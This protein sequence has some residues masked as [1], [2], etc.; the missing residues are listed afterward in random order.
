MRTGFR[1]VWIMCW[2]IPI[3][4]WDMESVKKIAESVGEVVV[5]D[6]EV[7]D[8]QRLDWARVLVKTLWSPLINHLVTANINGE[9]FVVKIV[10]ETC[11]SSWKCTC[12][13]LNFLDSSEEISS[14]ESEIG[15]DAASVCSQFDGEKPWWGWRRRKKV[16]SV[17]TA[18]RV[19]TEIP[20][21][22][23]GGPTNM[24]TSVN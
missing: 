21:T 20:L 4:A 9:E 8:Q 23:G 11:Y 10:E 17:R 22:V 7:E 3:H 12:R 2:G 5:V 15:P 1:L 16:R 18:G 6:E 24:L 13:R 19:E 14:G